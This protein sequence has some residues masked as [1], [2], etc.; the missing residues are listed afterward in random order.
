MQNS[1]KF[2]SKVRLSDLL[3]RLVPARNVLLLYP[4]GA[5]QICIKMH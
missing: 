4:S 2:K 1:R 3:N 5:S